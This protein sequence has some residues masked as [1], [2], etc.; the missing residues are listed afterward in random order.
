MLSFDNF[1]GFQNFSNQLLFL[2]NRSLRWP[3][4][5]N[6]SV[7]PSDLFQSYSNIESDAF[8]HDLVCFPTP[9][10]SYCT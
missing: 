9:N 3:R 5:Q 2:L 8:A 6:S 4:G 10:I 7:L 1:S